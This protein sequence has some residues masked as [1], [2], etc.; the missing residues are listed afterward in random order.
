MTSPL[1]KI[2]SGILN[3]DMKLVSEG[4]ENLTG[5][6]LLSVDK[7]SDPQEDFIAPTKN[8]SRGKTRLARTE[9][10]KAG[11]NQFLD[12]GTESKDIETPEIQ[13][14]ERNRPRASLI[15]AQCHICNKTD[16]IPDLL[17]QGREFYRCD[18]CSSR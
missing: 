2:R 4:F 16:R 3:D 11:E 18:K 13:L 6:T 12:D 8:K 5:E 10:S 9:P 1:D 17:M 14:T 7:S 15:D